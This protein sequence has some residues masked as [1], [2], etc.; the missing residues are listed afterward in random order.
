MKLINLSGSAGFI[1][2]N[3]LVNISAATQKI[4]QWYLN[5]K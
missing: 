5:N 4:I 2:L 3:Y 1:D